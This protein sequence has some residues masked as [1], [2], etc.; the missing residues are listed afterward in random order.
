MDRRMRATFF[1]S[2]AGIRPAVLVGTRGVGGVNNL[3]VFNSI[4]H[5]GA[6][7]PR[8]ALLFRPETVERHT[9]DNLRQTRSYSINFVRTEDYRKAHQTSAKY[10]AHVSEFEVVGFTPVIDDGFAAPSVQQAPIRLQMSFEYETEI[11]LNGT[12][13]V[14]GRIEKVFLS[15]DWSGQDGYVDH[16]A[17]GSLACVGLDAYFRVEGLGRLPYAR[18]EQASTIL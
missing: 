17:A 11:P 9:L 12:L 1:N 7:P 18:P 3:A 15:G 4:L 6:D 10:P 13:L 14:V 5:I 8:N 2:L 16:Q